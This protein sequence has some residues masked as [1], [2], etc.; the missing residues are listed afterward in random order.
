LFQ[1]AAVSTT[2]SL[3]LK[4]RL[5]EALD[6]CDDGELARALKEGGG[7]LDLQE[8]GEVVSLGALLVNRLVDLEPAFLSDLAGQATASLDDVELA[9]AAH[10][11]RK[12]VENPVVPALRAVMPDLLE[13]ACR[14]LEPAEDEHEERMAAARNRLRSLLLGEGTP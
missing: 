2:T 8:A 5:L 7:A 14:V 1:Q 9:D 6:E 4:R 11:L 13:L 3:R 10:H 12:G